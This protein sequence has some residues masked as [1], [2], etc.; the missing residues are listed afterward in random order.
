MR[1]KLKVMRVVERE[2]GFRR[3]RKSLNAYEANVQEHQGLQES[4][5]Y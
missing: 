2:R 3:R 1:V 5:P 4:F